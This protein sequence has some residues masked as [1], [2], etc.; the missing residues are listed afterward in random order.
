MSGSFVLYSI[1]AIFSLL[2]FL[3]KKKFSFWKDRGFVGPEPI[4]PFGSMKGVGSSITQAEAMK[5]IYD[6]YKGKGPV[7]GLFV[8]L[9]PSLLALD[10]DFIKNVLV[11]DFSSFTDRGLYYNKKDQPILAK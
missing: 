5:V 9:G 7:A 8:F 2:F 10:V 3:V 4:F 1:V 11:R 6:K